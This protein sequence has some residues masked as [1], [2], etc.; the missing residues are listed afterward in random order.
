[1]LMDLIWEHNPCGGEGD[2]NLSVEERLGKLETI[3]GDH[4]SEIY[5]LARI[6]KQSAID[7]R[8]EIVKPIAA[9]FKHLIPLYEA[10]VR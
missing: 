6:S 1:M 8:L 10:A 2:T 9:L 5:I 7:L 3:P 4:W